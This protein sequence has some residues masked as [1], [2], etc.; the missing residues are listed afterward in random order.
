[1]KIAI[2]GSRQ[3]DNYPLLKQQMQPYEQ[4]VTLVISGGAK[5]ADELAAQWSEEVIGQPPLVILPRWKDIEH[6]DAILKTDKNGESYDAAAGLRR[7]KEIANRAD[8][9]V[10]FWDG[11]SKG[12]KQIIAYAQQINTEIKII[13]Y[14]EAQQLCFPF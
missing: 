11:K 13:K 7:N 12:T 8:F 9:I 3:F 14:K 2:V 4:G 1:M 10:A 5:G 6:P